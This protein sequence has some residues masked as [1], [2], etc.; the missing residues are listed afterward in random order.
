M[1]KTL[2]IGWFLTGA[3]LVLLWQTQ[4]EPRRKNSKTELDNLDGKKLT[5]FPH[6]EENLKQAAG[7]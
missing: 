2:A 7:Q 3:L 5:R 4:T 1:D 6:I